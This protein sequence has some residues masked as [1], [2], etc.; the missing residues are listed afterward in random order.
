MGF[1]S[2][3]QALVELFPQVDARL[4]KAV[5]IEHAKDPDGAVEAILTEVLPFTSEK[6]FPV[7]R[8]NG[9]TAEMPSS[10][11]LESVPGEDANDSPLVNDAHN[12]DGDSLASSFYDANDTDELQNGN[13][14][15]E[16]LMPIT[17]C[18]ET[19]VEASQAEKLVVASGSLINECSKDDFIQGSGDYE[20]E[21]FVP[22]CDYQDKRTD[23][24]D[25]TNEASS[26]TA[27]TENPE[28]DVCLNNCL[29]ANQDCVK[30][31]PAFDY[32]PEQQSLDCDLSD[33]ASTEPEAEKEMSFFDGHNEEMSSYVNADLDF[34]DF[35]VIDDSAEG[36]MSLSTI[37]T[38]SGQICRINLVEGIIEDAK[39]YKD[40][41][42]SATES[43][44]RLIEDVEHQE[45][46]AEQ[47]KAAAARGGLDIL[48]KVEEVKKMLKHAKEA[49]EM[50]AGEVYGEK[51]ILA[52][53]V[54]ELQTRLFGLTDEKNKSLAILDETM[55]FHLYKANSKV[56]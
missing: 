22:S 44:L 6:K 36:E 9:K 52:T 2:V 19:I 33:R 10:L 42:L 54:R 23:D 1:N 53:E 8:N 12:V 21:S 28:A 46:E 45:N 39:N 26:S 27:N 34:Q 5:A 14:R 29:D 51:S 43:I 40:V 24:V 49:N 17:R 11:I 50:H 37:V 48:E 15:N 56:N 18:E 13:T 30:D 55:S 32:H 4:L 41:L 31:A 16:D 47:A 35:P 20:G 38:Q 3:Y 7:V 25:K